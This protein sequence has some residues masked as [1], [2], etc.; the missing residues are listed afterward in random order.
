MSVWRYIKID[1]LLI[2]FLPV[3]VYI[4]W[5][6]VQCRNTEQC[7]VEILYSPKDLPSSFDGDNEVSYKFNS[8]DY[9]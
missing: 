6:Y 3:D 7:K 9:F 8:C 1:Y 4:V 2:F 5:G